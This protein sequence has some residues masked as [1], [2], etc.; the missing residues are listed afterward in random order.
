MPVTQQQK[1]SLCY[2]FKIIVNSRLN[3]GYP[4]TKGILNKE[5]KWESFQPVSM[6]V[7]QQ[8]KEF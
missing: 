5:A 8:Q 7:T 3:A 4:A 1:E 6:P 2:L